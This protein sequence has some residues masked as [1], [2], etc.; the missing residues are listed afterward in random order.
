MIVYVQAFRRLYI[1]YLVRGSYTRPAKHGTALA[2]NLD[3]HSRTCEYLRRRVW[4]FLHKIN[5]LVT[6]SS[7]RVSHNHEDLCVLVST[8][9]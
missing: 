5:T 2:A 7:M 3:Y 8:A 4:P 6:A 9:L 1:I